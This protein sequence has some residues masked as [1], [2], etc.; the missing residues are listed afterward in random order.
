MIGGPETWPQGKLRFPIVHSQNIH[1]Q[2]IFVSGIR[3][4]DE[5]VEEADIEALARTDVALCVCFSWGAVTAAIGPSSVLE[6]SSWEKSP[7]LIRPWPDFVTT[8]ID[9][10]RMHDIDH[11]SSQIHIEY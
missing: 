10:L 3:L 2:V 4:E 9:L 7:S 5:D 11:R 8:R 1:I 6:S